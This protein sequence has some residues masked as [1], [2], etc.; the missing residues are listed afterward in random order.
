MKKEVKII[1]SIVDS[2]GIERVKEVKIL[3]SVLLYAISRNNGAKAPYTLYF[4]QEIETRTENNRGAILRGSG[5]AIESNHRK[6]ALQAFTTARLEELGFQSIMEEADNLEGKPFVLET[7]VE[8]SN[9]FDGLDVNISITETT[10]Q[11]SLTAEPKKA[12]KD[13][14]ELSF[15]SDLIYTERFLVAG[16][17]A[18]K[19]LQHDEFERPSKRI[20]PEA[21][22]KHF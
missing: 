22:A 2:Q 8:A 19:F 5:Y 15:G 16:T 4:E 7:K 6:T 14:V 17:P 3:S 1:G 11:P 18:F 13:G 12:G 9:L 21:A 10:E 20:T